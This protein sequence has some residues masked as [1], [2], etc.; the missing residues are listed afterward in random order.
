MRHL[1]LRSVKRC[2]AL[3]LTVLALPSAASSQ[4]VAGDRFR[5]NTGGCTIRS[6]SGAP[7][8]GLGSNC[9]LYVDTASGHVYAKI[10]STWRDL[11]LAGA[12]G[13]VLAGTG[14]SSTPS[15][16]ADPN[17]TTLTASDVV[18]SE[19]S[20]GGNID[21][22]AAGG[23]FMPKSAYTGS[24]GKID[25][26]WLTVYAA[27]LWVQSLVAAD[28]VATIGGRVL[29]AP[30]STLI[31]NVG[32]SDTSIAVK[33]SSWASGDR[34]L[35]E[36]N[37]S[38][39]WMALTSGP[40]ATSGGYSYDVTRNLDG[41]GANQW[42]AG[43]AVVNTGTTGD[44]FI[45]L[46]S[47]AGVL[48]GS[49]PT[50]VGNVRTGSTYSAVAPRW[51]IGNLNGL[52]GY[53]SD[54]Y[55]AAFGDPSAAWVKIDPT[56]GVRIGHNATTKVQIDASGNASFTGAITSTSGT[57]GGWTLGASSL[58]AT[59]LGLYSGA[60]N[61]ARVEVGSSSNVG[62][63]NSCNGSSDI[64]FWAGA[65]HSS[66]ASAPF[67]VTC[68]G[69]VT[70]TDATITGPSITLGEPSTSF[71]AKAQ[72]DFT[73]PSGF[74]W[75]QSGDVYRLGTLQNC[76]TGGSC[77][78]TSS[79]FIRNEIVGGTGGGNSSGTSY[80]YLSARGWNVTGGSQTHLAS[81]SLQ[82]DGGTPGLS[83]AT[84]SADAITIGTSGA[85][86]G[87]T[88]STFELNGTTS[89]KPTSGTTGVTASCNG[90][91]PITVTK[92]IITAC[93]PL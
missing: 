9:D 26:K 50:I 23:Y 60:A 85:S 4:T 81:L 57:I 8:G 66:R 48:S 72:I 40:S 46:Y 24:L 12:S 45:D 19:L 59:N 22:D 77:A 15:F 35:I 84:L 76:P 71:F 93:T 25:R 86:V 11:A 70:M 39:E 78:T 6:G 63:I 52:Y 55:G 21:V 29:V 83:W 47:D 2:A 80:T 13:T 20:S 41:S 74:G 68:G 38:V 18:S 34:V 14:T 51:A 69:S 27:E 58:T 32:V 73:R 10:G 65:A 79:V 82:S 75:G 30:T 89:V 53:G 44:G 16:T 67:R 5:L 88:S 91:Q 62:G 3:L 42:Y 49:G 17:V 31:S 90:T 33:T 1:F 43:D 54:T 37:G 56:N 7:S 36:V 64:A 28:T 92:G 61:T 87:V